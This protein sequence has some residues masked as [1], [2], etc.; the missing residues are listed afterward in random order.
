M[1]SER[2][3]WIV[4]YAEPADGRDRIAT[5]S[6]EAIAESAPPLRDLERVPG[7]DG[8]QLGKV[9]QATVQQAARFY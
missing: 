8:A 6:E 4:R 5:L 1:R 9:G 2:D 3:I 7:A